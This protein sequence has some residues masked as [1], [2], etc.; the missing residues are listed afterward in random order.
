MSPFNEDL[1]NDAADLIPD[2]TNEERAALISRLKRLS[3][4]YFQPDMTLKEAKATAKALQQSLRK[5][6]DLAK[7]LQRGW[8]DSLHVPIDLVVVPQAVVEL[9]TGVVDTHPDKIGMYPL[10]MPSL[11]CQVDDLVEYLDNFKVTGG[12]GGLVTQRIGAVKK[13]RLVESAARIWALATLTRISS[14]QGAVFIEVA[15]GAMTGS[16]NIAGIDRLIS[17]IAKEVAPP[18]SEE[19]VAAKL[20]DLK[21]QDVNHPR[22]LSDPLHIRYRRL[23]EAVL[24]EG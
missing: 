11:T 1:A 24:R 6:V 18:E 13:R 8:G 20:A 16:E 19:E 12:H 9:E 4:E 22:L 10:H 2:L 15:S 7:Q 23:L 21:L 14:S 17:E 5:T 3:D